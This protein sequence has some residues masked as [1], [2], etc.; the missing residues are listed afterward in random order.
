MLLR[1]PDDLGVHFCNPAYDGPVDALFDY[2]LSNGQLEHDL[3]PG[4]PDLSKRTRAGPFP[5]NGAAA[6]LIAWQVDFEPEA[7]WVVGYG[8]EGEVGPNW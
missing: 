1:G 2:T 6:P 5:G 8:R 4:P 3:A 7:R